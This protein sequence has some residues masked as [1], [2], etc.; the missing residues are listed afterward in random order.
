[1][2]HSNSCFTS[3]ESAFQT[4]ARLSTDPESSRRGEEALKLPGCCFAHLREKIGP[5][6]RASERTSEPSLA[7]HRR[8]T[9]SYEPVASRLPHGDQSSVVTSRV[10]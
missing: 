7:D 3:P 1:M 2:W 8:A 9:P 6:C 10:L 4:I 5:E